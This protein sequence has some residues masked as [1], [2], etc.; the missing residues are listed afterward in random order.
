MKKL[1]IVLAF[2]FI[3]T[4][5]YSCTGGG[6]V[7]TGSSYGFGSYGGYGGYGSYGGYGGYGRYGG[8]GYRTNVYPNI[9]RSYYSG[10]YRR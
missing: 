2:A 9:N 4:T 3:A 1:L 7:S 6:Y 5:F 10:G 8:Y